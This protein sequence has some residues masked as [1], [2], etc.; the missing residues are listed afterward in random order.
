MNGSAGICD[1]FLP[2]RIDLK[3]S[4]SGPLSGL[5]FAAKDL[6]DVRRTSKGA[7]HYGLDR[8][9][10]LLAHRHCTWLQKTKVDSTDGAPG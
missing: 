1:A 2:A 10:C 9:P 7:L 3:A 8:P 6:Y 5:T 4:E